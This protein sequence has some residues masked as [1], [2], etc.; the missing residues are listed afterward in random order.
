[1]A[2]YS[3]HVS[4]VSRAA[5]SSAV[6]S[7]SYITSRPMLDERTGERYWGFG[8]RERVELVGVALPSGAPRSWADPAVLANAMEAAE[9]RTDGRPAKKIMVAL[10][11]ELSTVQQ[12][13]AVEAFVGQCLISRGYA[14]VWAIHTDKDGRNP[15]AHII[16]ANRRLGTNGKWLAKSRSTFAL[17]EHGQRIPVIDPATGEQKRR[18]NGRLVWKR[19][20]I[21]DN[22]LDSVEELKYMRA[23][24]ADTC[25]RLLPDGTRIDHRTLEAQGIDRIP[26][27]HEGYAAREI[28]KRGGLSP[29]CEENRRIRQTNRLL[30]R[31]HSELADLRDRLANLMQRLTHGRH[32]TPEPTQE[33]TPRARTR[34]ELV[35]RFKTKT[36]ARRQEQPRPARRARGHASRPQQTPN[37]MTEARRQLEAARDRAIEQARRAYFDA[38]EMYRH[39]TGRL[40]DADPPSWPTIRAHTAPM[41]HAFEQAGKVG[42]LRRRKL[43]RQ[44]EQTAAERYQSLHEAA[45][46]LRLPD[47]PPHDIDELHRLENDLRAQA[48]AHDLRHYEDTRAQARERLDQTQNQ[49]ITNTDIRELANQIRH[50]QAKQMN[51]A[52]THTAPP[53]ARTT[54]QPERPEHVDSPFSV[55]WGIDTNSD[56]NRHHG[57]RR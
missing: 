37:P 17:D 49:L 16:V 28:E 18:A 23:Q 27:I 53:R 31:L 2:I 55:D 42:I 21:S 39:E 30:A 57:M 10:P 51:T 34:E 12:E 5:G 13:R 1:M 4:N 24:W 45:P 48:T 54:S 52:D 44:A 38:D 43:R 36:E 20:T 29:L 8:R 41:Q 47:Q 22:P 14:A 33:A 25:N 15:H 9:K 3:M 50:E 35:A 19:T 7:V 56:P 46:W 40:Q 11:R 6:A 32:H 26:T